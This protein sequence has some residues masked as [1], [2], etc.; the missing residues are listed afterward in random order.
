[1]YGQF[2]LR[3]E[4]VFAY[5][6]ES[7]PSLREYKEPTFDEDGRPESK[8]SMKGLQQMI[9]GPHQ[10]A[11]ENQKFQY[12]WELIAENYSRRQL[13]FQTDK[14]K[15]LAGVV[16]TIER[17]SGMTYHAGIWREEAWRGLL[18]EVDRK[19][20]T[21]AEELKEHERLTEV[22]PSWSW[23]SVSEP[24]H[25]IDSHSHTV[26]VHDGTSLK[27]SY[28]EFTIDDKLSLY[29]K[30][31]WIS[32]RKMAEDKGK[33]IA[34]EFPFRVDDMNCVLTADEYITDDS[35]DAQLIFISKEY[36]GD[37]LTGLVVHE[38]RR[39]GLV[40]LCTVEKEEYEQLHTTVIEI[41]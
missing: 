31:K 15:A 27:Y 8:S 25:F 12:P 22:A 35:V 14:I 17:T 16:T 1:V 33:K 34:G 21:L 39:V 24:V 7:I 23:L 41:E 3:W 37:R 11:Y 28:G 29:G 19:H 40:Q 18:W 6:T 10:G 26:L 2:G 13:T 30:Y 32:V 4:C 9:Y 36:G 5:G 20:P 38:G